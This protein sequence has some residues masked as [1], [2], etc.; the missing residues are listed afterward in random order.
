[1][2]VRIVADDMA[3]EKGFSSKYVGKYGTIIEWKPNPDREDGVIPVIQLDDGT[4]ICNKKVWW[5]KI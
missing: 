4:I 5:T 3:E 2:R 1:M